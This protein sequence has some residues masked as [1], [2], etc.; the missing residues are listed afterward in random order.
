MDIS[1]GWPSDTQAIVI[2][3]AHSQDL[4][5]SHSNLI[6]PILEITDFKGWECI[7]YPC[8]SMK[9]N[10]NDLEFNEFLAVLDLIENDIV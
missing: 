1:E 7:W 9:I 4:A 6:K 10:D 2:F 5:H 3:E 8:I